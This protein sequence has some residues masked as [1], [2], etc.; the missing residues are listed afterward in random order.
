[1]RREFV[2]HER[3][4]HGKRLGDADRLNLQRLA[5][6]ACPQPLTTQAVEVLELVHEGVRPGVQLRIHAPILADNDR[7]AIGRRVEL[8]LSGRWPIQLADDVLH[9]G[10]CLV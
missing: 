3:P 9:G 8:R 2:Q 10:D 4:L 5:A 1:L 7:S 6:A